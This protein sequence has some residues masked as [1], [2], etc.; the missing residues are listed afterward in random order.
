MLIKINGTGLQQAGCGQVLYKPPHAVVSILLHA[1]VSSAL[2]KSCG[3]DCQATFQLCR[4]FVLAAKCLWGSRQQ[5]PNMIVGE[6]N[7][8][9]TP[10]VKGQVGKWIPSFLPLVLKSVCRSSPELAR[11]QHCCSSTSQEPTHKHPFAP[12]VGQQLEPHS[13]IQ[14]PWPPAA[15][16]CSK[17]WRNVSFIFFLLFLHNFMRAMTN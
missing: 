8:T 14:V 15:N 5:P 6:L 7:Q 2:D 13:M 3:A 17:N 10:N 12:E 11:P 4:A 1:S 9:W 16:L